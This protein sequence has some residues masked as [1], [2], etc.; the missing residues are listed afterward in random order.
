[1]RHV[2]GRGFRRCGNTRAPRRRQS[3]HLRVRRPRAPQ[4]GRVGRGH[5]GVQRRPRHE[6]DPRGRGRALPE[7]ARRR[8]RTGG[9]AQD[10]RRGIHQGVRDRGE[11]DRGCGLSGAGHHLS[12]RHR[13]RQGQ[14]RRHQIASQRRGASLRRRLQGD[15][16][17]VAGSVQ[18]R[19]A[20]RRRRAGPARFRR[21]ASAL[22]R[23]RACHSHHGGGHARKA[24]DPP[25]RGL[26]FPGGSGQSGACRQDLAVLCGHHQQ[27]NGGR[28]G[29]FPYV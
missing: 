3:A 9:K 20:P 26:H 17:A 22:P 5:V 23:P 19:G 6:S 13:E 29:G 7:K 28:P 4:K 27:Q 2:R 11:E 12:R 16:G 10:H 24:G 14:V 1:M 18:G 21:A 25:R 15:R 8:L